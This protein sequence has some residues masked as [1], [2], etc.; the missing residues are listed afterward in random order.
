MPVK[1]KKKEKTMDTENDTVAHDR[2]I[3]LGIIVY[4]SET[5]LAQERTI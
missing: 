2:R 3:T 1:K 5:K 4:Q